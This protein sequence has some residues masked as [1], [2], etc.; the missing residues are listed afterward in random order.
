MCRYGLKIEQPEVLIDK[1]G[2]VGLKRFSTATKPH[3]T[4]RE[5][6]EPVFSELS[7]PKY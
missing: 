7:V 3:G 4:I 1:L 6:L 2:T 5:M